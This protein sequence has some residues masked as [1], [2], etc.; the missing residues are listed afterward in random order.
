MDRPV[1]LTLLTCAAHFDE[2]RATLH[3]V[4][5]RR[6]IDPLPRVERSPDPTDDFL[7]ALSEG[8]RVD[9]ETDRFRAEIAALLV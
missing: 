9:T 3:K 7:L 8:G 1:N 4:T 5:R 6:G 2:L